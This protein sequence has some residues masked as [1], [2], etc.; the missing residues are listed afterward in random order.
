L[1][2]SRALNRP[3]VFARALGGMALRLR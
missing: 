3:D 1:V 2:L